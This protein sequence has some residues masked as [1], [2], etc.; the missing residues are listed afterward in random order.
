MRDPVKC[1]TPPP[2]YTA[3]PSPRRY[4]VRTAQEV[5]AG[6]ATDSFASPGFKYGAPVLIRAVRPTDQDEWLVPVVSDGRT[7]AVLA[8]SIFPDGT[9]SAG[10]LTGWDGRFPHAMAPDAA[11]AAGGTA[12]DPARRSVELAW[13]VVDPRSGGPA[14]ETLPFYLVTR[15]SGARVLVM[16]GGGVVEASA[17]GVP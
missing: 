10:I 11:L 2:G 7:N 3:P 5:L 8:I 1:S 14:S 12:A 13:A 16:Q 17:A 15:K 4:P 9:G 6:L